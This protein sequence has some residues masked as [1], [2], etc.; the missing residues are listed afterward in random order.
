MKSQEEMLSA[1]LQVKARVLVD[2]DLLQLPEKC[3]PCSG[4]I[5]PSRLGSSAQRVP[6]GTA[7][8]M[9]RQATVLFLL[10][11][12]QHSGSLATCPLQIDRPGAANGRDWGQSKEKRS[13]RGPSVG[14]SL[15]L[16]SQRQAAAGPSCCS[17]KV[18]L[19]PAPSPPDT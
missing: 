16:L 12:E 19:F 18:N 14:E 3:E 1:A 11:W 13:G 4:P 9:E 8:V 15:F 6:G 7:D 5:G 10:V 2:Y 17:L